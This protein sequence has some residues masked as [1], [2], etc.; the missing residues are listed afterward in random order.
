MKVLFVEFVG[1]CLL[2][3]LQE[4]FLNIFFT[5]LTWSILLTSLQWGFPLYMLLGGTMSN[6]PWCRF[7]VYSEIL[8][9]VYT[10]L[11]LVMFSG[12]LF[13]VMLSRTFFCFYFCHVNWK[14][15]CPVLCE[16]LCHVLREVV[17]CQVL[18]VWQVAFSE[19]K[20]FALL[21][22]GRSFF[23]LFSGRLFSFMF[24]WRLL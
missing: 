6:L 3:P 20:F 7:Y 11:F 9:Y 5:V 13:S 15:L 2:Q 22:S 12:S 23:V 14:V 10:R 1:E 19:V 16:V 4:S 21:L 18:S 17:L 8:C 24:S